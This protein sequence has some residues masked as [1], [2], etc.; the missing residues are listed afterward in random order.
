VGWSVVVLSTS[1]LKMRVEGWRLD[2]YRPGRDRFAIQLGEESPRLCDGDVNG[3][4][5]AELTHDPAAPPVST[6]AGLHE[7]LPIAGEGRGLAPLLGLDVGEPSVDHLGKKQ[8]RTLG[9]G[10]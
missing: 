2:I 7:K 1:K 9:N 8:P 10:P 4:A 5:S 6:V 3:N